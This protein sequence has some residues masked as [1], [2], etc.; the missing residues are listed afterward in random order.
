ML[1]EGR[2]EGEMFTKDAEKE[3]ITEENKRHSCRSKKIKRSKE[4]NKRC[5]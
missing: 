1:R 2:H 3:R 4:R 5:R